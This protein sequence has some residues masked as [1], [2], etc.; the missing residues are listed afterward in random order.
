MM[1]KNNY[2]VPRESTAKKAKSTFDNEEQLCGRSRRYEMREEHR[3]FLVMRNNYKFQMITTA[4]KAQSILD[5][6]EQLCGS[7][8]MKCQEGAFYP[9]W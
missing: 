2:A 9:S 5:N 6:K 1:M 4:M 8:G 3:L 7:D